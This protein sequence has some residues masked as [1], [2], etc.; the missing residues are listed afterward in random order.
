MGDENLHYTPFPERDPHVE[1]IEAIGQTHAREPGNPSGG[2]EGRIVRVREMPRAAAM[3]ALTSWIADGA[4]EIESPAGIRAVERSRRD[5]ATG[6][7]RLQRMAVGPG[8]P[9]RVLNW[10]AITPTTSEDRAA[11]EAGFESIT[12]SP[13]PPPP[14]RKPNPHLGWTA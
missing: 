5:T 6:L 11:W 8:D 3:D 9:A 2:I 1:R 13:S 10:S 4:V 7:P 14:P 12:H